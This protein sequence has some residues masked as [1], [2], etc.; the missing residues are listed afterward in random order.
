MPKRP[1]PP[2]PGRRKK[3][4]KVW[5]LKRRMIAVELEESGERWRSGDVA[6]AGRFF[7]QAI[8]AYE[9]TLAR[10]PDNFDA[11]Y[12][13]ARLQYTLTQLPL[14]T[15]FFPATST[16]E[17]RLLSAVE[18]H[19]ECNDLEKNSSDI[20]FNYGQTLHSLGEFYSNKP[21]S[22]EDDDE[23]ESREIA[24]LERAKAAFEQS[25]ETL[26]QC[27]TVQE[28][29]YKSQSLNPLPED[30]DMNDEEEGDSSEEAEDGGIK[31]PTAE[32][33][34]SSASSR[35]S[36]SA[37]GNSTQWA[38]ILEPTTK[39][40]I[41]DTALTMLEVQTAILSTLSSSPHLTRKLITQSHLENLTSH[42]SS[43]L[44]NYILPIAS[45]LHTPETSQLLSLEPTE[46]KEKELESL[47]SRANF[48]T[49]LSETKY[50]LSLS[51][52]DLWESD[53]KSAFSPFQLHENDPIDPTTS[54]MTLCDRSTAYT[55]LSTT[56]H[57]SH[58]LKSWKLLS[59]IPVQDLTSAVKLA[60]E[61][62]KPGIYLAR[63]N[64]ELLRSR[65]NAEPALRGKEVLLKNAG[66]YYRGVIAA[67]GSG[68]IG[69]VDGVK[70]KELAE[71]A[72]IKESIIKLELEGDILPLKTIIRGGVAREAVWRI[73]KT[74]VEE[75]LFGR[76]ILT[77][78]ET[79][80]RA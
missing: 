57:P 77:P 1:H 42:A 60:P 31:L 50:H 39:L 35:S 75:G 65:V 30:D 3:T 80:L 24:R 18:A 28:G 37:G 47:L 48:L 63:G 14:P 52:P 76:E 73:L 9:S 71:E 41:L 33:R 54:W 69:A 6:K 55:T 17:S 78:V 40:S 74:A 20:L 21:E 13:R 59:T 79:V 46:I 58:P 38:T 67:A 56:I 25:W 36:N 53:L 15:T 66:V 62:E 8:A 49:A 34:N 44:Q 72:K 11:R 64:L 45:T 43:T 29:E 4:P 23:D 70:V 68:L 26:R 12:N 61:K 32:R 19:R 5:C 10:Y 22:E 27:L 7:V 2:P 51:T 16:A